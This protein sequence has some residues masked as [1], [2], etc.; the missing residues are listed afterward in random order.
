VQSS[1]LALMI[2]KGEIPPI[3]AAIFADTQW[4]PRAVY[5]WLDWLELQLPFPVY[6]VTAGNIRENLMRNSTG[7]QFAAIPWFTLNPDGSLGMGR[8]QCTS[9]YKLNP[10]RRKT[11][12]LCGYMPRKRIP[13]GTCETLVGISTDEAL[14]M[15]PSTDRWNTNIF[16][17]IDVGMSRSDCLAWMKGY[18]YP[19]PVKSSCLGC[20][21]HSNT[22]WR[23]IKADPAAWADVLE[24]DAAIRVSKLRGLQF[25]HAKRIPLAD[26]DLSPKSI[27]VDPQLDMFI[28]ECEG[29]C[30]V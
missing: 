4:E 30:G 14:R 20:P 25:M 27:A 15:K 5:E 8:R 24:V 2:A 9:E 3:D 12:E 1:T 26:V 29:I 13:V 11:R 21:Y 18:G 10:I 23:E 19:E 22:Q 28:N 7:Q 6:R 17:L 16:P